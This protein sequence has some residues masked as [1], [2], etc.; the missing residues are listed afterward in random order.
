VIGSGPGGAITAALLAEA[1]REVLLLEEG[2]H[3][4]LDSCIPFTRQEMEQKYRNGGL[5]VA[6]GRYKISYVEGRCVGG[7][8]EINSGLYHRTPAD[9]LEN[10]RQVYWIEGFSEAELTP[11]FSAC[12]RDVSVA[13]L[14]GAAPAAS[15]KLHHG[16]QRLGWQSLEVPRWFAYTPAASPDASEG[17]KQSMTQ[18]FIPRAL[19]AGATLLPDTRIVRL[20]RTRAGWRLWVEH[21]LAGAR[22]R[23]L[24][25]DAT[26][27]FVAGGAIQTPALPR[28]S[29]IKS[30]VGNSLKFHPTVKVVACFPEAVNSIDMGVPVHQVKQF[31]PWFN[32]G[33]A[34]STP[35]YLALALVDHPRDLVNVH[36]QWCHMAVY[37]AMIGGG[38]GLVRPVPCYRDPLIRYRLR[39]TDL[40]DL[41]DALRQ[42]CRVLL[43]AGAEALYPS[44]S[45]HPV[46]RSAVDLTCISRPLPPTRTSL[47]IVHLMASCPM[48]ENRRLAAVNSFGKV[49]GLEDLYIADASLLGGAPGV[50]PQVTKDFV[51]VKPD[52]ECSSSD[53][54]FGNIQH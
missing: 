6:L 17:I 44:I 34:I 53:S 54:N 2:P 27:V 5:T 29:G 43:A 51:E 28:R 45:G 31:A 46:I 52:A 42:L 3:L 20:T 36:S 9:I 18:T 1:G 16:A 32:F 48:G 11:H 14:P 8:S 15:L 25:I 13:Y 24:A 49:H 26:T 4:P 33:C 7:G 30:N 41:S 37:Y 40:Y 38:Q 35:P 50:N 19:A 23:R 22:K 21:F 10:W 47:M 39:A 12:E